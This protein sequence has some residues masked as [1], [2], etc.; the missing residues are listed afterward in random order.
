VMCEFETYGNTLPGSPWE[1]RYLEEGD[2]MELS[3]MTLEQL[4]AAL[5][6]N[7]QIRITANK[8]RD[9]IEEE[10]CKRVNQLE[11]QNRG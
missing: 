5:K 4:A 10:I 1:N 2:E 3:E 7:R 9:S 6:I 8:E 11:E